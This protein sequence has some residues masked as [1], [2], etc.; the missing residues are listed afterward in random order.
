[1]MFGGQNFH[2]FAHQSYTNNMDLDDLLQQIFGN[3]GGSRFD[4]GGF[5]GGFGDF[6][7]QNLDTNVK[8][9][10]PFETSIIGGKHHVSINNE[11]FDIKIP[12]GI[13]TGETLRVRGKG[14]SSGGR[15]GDLLIKIEI[16]PNSEYER[17]G[18]DLIKTFDLS[19]KTA[20]FGGKCDINTIH[21]E[22]TLKIPQNT[23]NGQR[24]RV[25]GLGVLN[26][27]SHIKGDLYL[28]ANVILPDI[29]KLDSEL[30]E[31]MRNKLMEI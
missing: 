8:L 3:R 29:E 7:S 9:T 10:I 27:K 26:R 31:L 24:F 30:V 19:L 1:S 5:G 17:V 12:E 13:G 20:M 6:A 4:F 23:K 2:D 28:K 11:S 22:I 14:K 18:D 15:R 16:A 21:K 25:K